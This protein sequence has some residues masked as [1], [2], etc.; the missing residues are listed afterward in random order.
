MWK[1]AFMGRMVGQSEWRIT[2]LGVENEELQSDAAHSKI[3]GPVTVVQGSDGHLLED[4][5]YWAGWPPCYPRML[6]TNTHMLVDD[7]EEK[8]RAIIKAIEK[9]KIQLLPGSAEQDAREREEWISALHCLRECISLKWFASDLDKATKIP[10]TKNSDR[11][12]IQ[13]LCELLREALSFALERKVDSVDAASS[14]IELN[15]VARCSRNAY[16]M[17]TYAAFLYVEDIALFHETELEK[18]VE[19]D[20]ISLFERAQQK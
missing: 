13:E 10:L 9:V 4:P 8:N 14:V 15:Q 6:R 20:C 17:T 16:N 5:C 1:D 7:A 3:S 12:A 19:D 11:G 18:L 2:R